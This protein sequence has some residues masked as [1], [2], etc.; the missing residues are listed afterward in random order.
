MRLFLEI[1]RILAWEVLGAHHAAVNAQWRELRRVINGDPD[2]PLHAA[3][4]ESTGKSYC[5]LGV[6]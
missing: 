3:D 1:T 2:V 4:L 5:G 6:F